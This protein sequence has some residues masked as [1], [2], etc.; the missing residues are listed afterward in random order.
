[1]VVAAGLL[2]LGIVGLVWGL[3]G[4]PE[5]SGINA[6]GALGS[7]S[8]VLPTGMWAHLAHMVLGA[9]GLVLVL[10]RGGEAARRYVLFSGVV[11]LVWALMRF[12]FED[13]VT[14]ALRG[15]TYPGWWHL[16]GAF[17]V[18]AIGFGLR[19]RRP[20]KSPKSLEEISGE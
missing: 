19:S 18:T 9:A 2:A 11:L 6:A 20:R 5:G 7:R 17:I 10:F 4:A 8:G 12:I 15:W 16:G 1:M 13:P 14:A 3:G